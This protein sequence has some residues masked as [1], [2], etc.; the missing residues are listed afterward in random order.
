MDFPGKISSAETGNGGF[1][2]GKNGGETCK[3]SRNK[4][5]VDH[6]DYHGDYSEI[7]YHG[8]Q[9]VEKTIVGNHHGIKIGAAFD[10]GDFTNTNSQIYR[11]QDFAYRC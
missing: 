8:I 9:W 3:C 6:G 7:E 5:S 2:S 4:Q 11:T 10:L 1:S